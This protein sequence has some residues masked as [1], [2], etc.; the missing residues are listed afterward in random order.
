MSPGPNSCDVLGVLAGEHDQLADALLGVGARVQHL[1]FRRQRPLVDAQQVDAPGERVGAR[2]EHVGEQLPVLRRRELDFADHQRAVLD[3]RGQ[4]L[5]DRVEQ[6][7]RAEVARGDTAYDREDL[8][9]VGALLE[10]VDDLLVGDLLALEVALHQRV[11]H[12]AD[13]VHQ[14]LA[15]FGR[16]LLE[17][18]WDRDLV[19]GAA[20]RSGLCAKRLHVDEV[21]DTLDVV[22]GA[23]R[24]LRSDDVRTEGGLEL[25]ERAIEVRALAVEHVDEQHARDVE[26]GCTRPQPGGRD[27]DAHHGVDDEHGGLA[28]AQRTER[29]GD[30]AR[31]AGGIQQVDLAL[32]PLQRAERRG[33]RHLARLLVGIGVRHGRALRH[34]AEAADRPRLEQQRLMQR[35]LPRPAMSDEG[36]VANTIRWGVHECLLL[37]VRAP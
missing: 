36:H 15:I 25:V 13:L 28:H 14:L 9:V 4:V 2:L 34:G 32:L 20:L 1:A 35:G 22:L 6:A 7:R 27:L 10:R 26:L 23:D 18:D 8:A 17:P 19:R 11:G 16:A 29:V 24:D 33:D 12:F 30:E 21:D 3:R 37:R 31:L 5:D